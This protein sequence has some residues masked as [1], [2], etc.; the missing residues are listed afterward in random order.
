MVC[1]NDDFLSAVEGKR[2][3]GQMKVDRM[4]QP[5]LVAEEDEGWNMTVAPLIQKGARPQESSGRSRS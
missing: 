4:S 5:P 1:Q 3:E 2:S